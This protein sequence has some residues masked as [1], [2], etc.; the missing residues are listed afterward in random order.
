MKIKNISSAMLQLD[1][2]NVHFSRSLRPK[3][4]TPLTEQE[5]I[6]FNQDPGCQA[7][8]NGHFVKIIDIPEEQ[9]ELVTDVGTTYDVDQ[10]NDM[11][12]KNNVTAFAKFIPN[13]T[14]AE[15]ETAVKLAVDKGITNPGIVALIKKYCDVDLINAISVNHQAEEK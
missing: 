13:A 10:I 8:L 2:P 11:L 1:I 6:E 15:K 3:Q 12:D 9:K 4:E 14:T 5:F 7:L